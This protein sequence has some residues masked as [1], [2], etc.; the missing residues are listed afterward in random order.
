MRPTSI[1]IVLAS[2]LLPATA[3]AG[4]EGTYQVKGNNPDDAGDYTGK[5]EVTRKGEVYQVV[6]KIGDDETVG[7]GIG[8][9][10]VDGRMI[11]G[12]ASDADTGISVSYVSEETAGNATYTES[13]DGRW[14]GVWI[15]QGATTVSTEEWTPDLPKVANDQ[16]DNGAKLS[17]KS[18][19]AKID[20]AASEDI[21]V[22]D[23]PKRTM[24][25]PLP[26]NASPKS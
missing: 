12:P 14:R 7:V 11:T 8:T 18:R 6:W 26:A 19:A 1:A 9:R 25:S 15:Y 4:P 24:S 16:R 5:V 10:I 22:N 23:T 2:I 20:D 17:S 13:P 3:M 21:K